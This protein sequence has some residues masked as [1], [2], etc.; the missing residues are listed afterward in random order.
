MLQAPRGDRLTMLTR[1]ELQHIGSLVTIMGTDNC[2]GALWI[3][4]GHGV[5]DAQYG[6]VPLTDDE[7]KAHN[8]AFDKA[9]LD[10]L[11]NCC[12]VGQNGTFYFNKEHRRIG[13]W[14]GTVVA[15][16]SNVQVNGNS[17]TFK[18]NNKV[19]RGRLRKTA[20]LFSFKRI[21]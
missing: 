12:E 6:K 10:G 1:E 14:L 3:A 15:E 16:G 4:A 21:K 2:L 7:A 5:Y 13:T 19:F 11:D 17:I 20:D 9:L 8:A 18:R